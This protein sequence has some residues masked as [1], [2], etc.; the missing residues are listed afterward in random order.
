MQNL[1][2]LVQGRQ[3]GVL[4]GKAQRYAMKLGAS[5]Q[6]HG[7]LFAMVGLYVAL[8][9][10][11]QYLIGG[12]VS[13]DPISVLQGK[14]S[15]LILPLMLIGIFF[16]R[17]FNMIVFVRPEHPLSYLA[18]DVG[19]F[20]LKPSRLLVA[21]PTTI[22]VIYFVQCYSSIK[23]AIPFVQAFSWDVTFMEL[24]RALHFGMD[25]WRILQPVLGFWWVTTFINFC[26][27]VWFLV[28]WFVLVSLAFSDRNFALRLQYFVSFTLTWMIGG[29]IL[30]MVFSSAGPAYYGLLGLGPDPYKDL[31]SYLH[32]AHELGN[33]PA[34]T[35]QAL[36]WESWQN[37]NKGIVAGISAMPSMHNATTVLLALLGWRVS[38]FWGIAGT[39]FAAIILV[40]SVHLG[41]HYA[42]DG[43]L[44]IAIALSVWWVSGHLVRWYL[45]LPFMQE[46]LAIIREGE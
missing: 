24:D 15:T 25:P 23:H 4:V 43:Y 27:N 26:Y 45:A 17:L 36:L 7:L 10:Y 38:R 22:A 1:S 35:T 14:I 9:Y 2:V 30:A 16:I 46:R 41:W 40:G 5:F 11:V 20:F 37:G 39:V 28:L 12:E 6:L 21:I 29:S 18:S 32:G 19:G 44:G 8:V 42:V 34:L 3:A 31:M 33:V 13:L